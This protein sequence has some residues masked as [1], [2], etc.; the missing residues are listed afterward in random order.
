MSR[1][2][3]I[4]RA[5][6]CRS[7][8]HFFALDALPR[9][10]TA[11]GKRLASL[12]LRYHDDYLVGAKA[13]DQTFRDFKNHVLHVQDG[14]WGGA[15][16][17]ASRWLDE[18]INYLD[19]GKWKKAAYACGVLSHYFTDP[20]MPLHTAQSEREGIVHRAME[21]SVCKSYDA[22]LT[23]SSGQASRV[24]FQLASTGDWI[25]QAVIAGATLANRYYDQL[26]DEYDIEQGS[27][28]PPDGL[29]ATSRRVL[30]DLFELAITGWAN[31]LSRI[32]DETTAEIPTFSLTIPSLL[33]R[34]LLEGLS[35]ERA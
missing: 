35:W 30:S 32:S 15:P 18:T 24:H 13:P 6:R 20:M 16:R 10:E 7:T 29:N 23:A 4:L 3:T 14:N 22:I 26:I 9:V 28:N 21:W 8:H 5:A 2:I 25:G 34:P 27:R 33:A 17:A 12:L 19:H 1:M 31:V 11:A